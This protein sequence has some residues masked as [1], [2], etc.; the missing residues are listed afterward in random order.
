[1]TDHVNPACALRTVIL[2]LILACSV[3][4]PARGEDSSTLAKRQDT[5]RGELAR[6]NSGVVIGLKNEAEVADDW[7]TL[8]DVAGLTGPGAEALGAFPVARIGAY[9]VDVEVTTVVSAAT[10][11]R[12]LGRIGV[13]WAHVDL[14]GFAQ[15]KAIRVAYIEGDEAESANDSQRGDDDRQASNPSN[16]DAGSHPLRSQLLG[17]VKMLSAE[18]PGRWEHSLTDQDAAWIDR[19]PRDEN[20]RFEVE[21]VVTQVPGRVPVLVRRFAGR[22]LIE[23]R[24]MLLQVEQLADV[25]VMRRS[26]V[27]GDVIGPDDV[28]L[29][30]RRLTGSQLVP[31]TEVDRVI[32]QTLVASLRAGATVA[33]SQVRAPLAAARQDEVIVQSVVGGVMLTMRGRAMEDGRIGEMIR[34]QHGNS[35]NVINAML[36]G[37][38]L[39][40][41]PDNPGVGEGR[42]QSRQE[43]RP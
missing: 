30:S 18:Q 10:I 21:P 43:D 36:I 12:D 29:E 16:G 4:I 25:V 33:A 28:K 13:N 27:R 22:E 14:R 34:I 3:A 37:D 19:L 5:F 23:Q 32:G 31:V 17:L 15:C 35:R 40:R 26:M 6:I 39:A 24:R 7:V 42:V 11:R 1:M 9:Q 20:E 38:R 41:V 2:S 8:G